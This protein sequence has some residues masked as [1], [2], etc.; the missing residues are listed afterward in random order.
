MAEKIGLI[1]EDT[2]EKE[3]ELPTGRGVPLLAGL[4][5][6]LMVLIFGN[7]GTVRM[8]VQGFQ[9]IAAPGGSVENAVFY[10]RW[11]WFFQGIGKYPEPVHHSLILRET[12]TGF[13]AGQFRAR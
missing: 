4:S 8:I 6:S 2:Q 3:E 11:L 13:P 10:M 9:R 12:G 1:E 5:A 7:L